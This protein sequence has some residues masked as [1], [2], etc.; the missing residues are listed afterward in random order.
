MHI[1]YD[2]ILI[3]NTVVN[4]IASIINYKISKKYFN[5]T[6]HFVL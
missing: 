2:I 4:T 3:V 6:L 5:I 1:T